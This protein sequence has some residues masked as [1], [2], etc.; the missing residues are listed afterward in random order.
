[1]SVRLTDGLSPSSVKYPSYGSFEP[2][3]SIPKAPVKSTSQKISIWIVELAQRISA[4]VRRCLGCLAPSYISLS[5]RD[6]E[7]IE[8][9]SPSGSER[10][11]PLP[12]VMLLGSPNAVVETVTSAKANLDQPGAPQDL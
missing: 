7:S 12:R 1:M 5:A 8:T 3:E 11:S 2:V 6:F 9:A 10:S 4:V